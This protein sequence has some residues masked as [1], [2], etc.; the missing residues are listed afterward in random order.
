MSLYGLRPYDFNDVSPVERSLKSL[1]RSPQKQLARSPVQLGLKLHCVRRRRRKRPGFEYF[2]R[3]VR[4]LELSIAIF[5][6]GPS[7]G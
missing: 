6:A 5:F 7:Q 3:F 4:L 2:K 1:S